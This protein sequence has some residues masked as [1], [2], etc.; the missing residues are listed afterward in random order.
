MTRK[1][2][3]HIYMMLMMVS[4]L[5]FSIGAPSSNPN[6]KYRYH[7]LGLVGISCKTGVCANPHL[8]IIYPSPTV[9]VAGSNAMNFANPVRRDVVS[10]GNSS[11]DNVTIRFV[12]DNPGPWFLHWRVIPLH[13]TRS[14]SH[15]SVCSHIDWNLN[16]WVTSMIPELIPVSSGFTAMA[17]APNKTAYEQSA[18]IP[19]TSSTSLC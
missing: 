15:E 12:M 16:Q 13:P 4:F 8:G 19:R 7:T 18:V 11:T 3:W 17:E 10:S 14:R 9:R 1:T 5:R 2:L 6:R